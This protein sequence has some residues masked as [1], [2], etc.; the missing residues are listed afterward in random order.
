VLETTGRTPDELARL[1]D[2][3]SASELRLPPNPLRQRLE[4]DLLSDAEREALARGEALFVS[5]GRRGRRPGAL[6]A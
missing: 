3:Y 4:Q 1:I 2:L 6:R 5:T